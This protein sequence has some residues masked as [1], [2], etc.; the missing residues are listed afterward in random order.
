MYTKNINGLAR[1]AVD[2][3]VLRDVSEI[4]CDSSH[5]PNPFFAVRGGKNKEIGLRK[6]GFGSFFV[7]H[8]PP[9]KNCSQMG[10]KPILINWGKLADFAD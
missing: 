4:R 7:G 8:P 1:N 3:A 10:R 5:D 9:R 6:S 2:F